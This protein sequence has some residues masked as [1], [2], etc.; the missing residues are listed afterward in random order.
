MEQMSLSLKNVTKTYPGV[1]ALNNISLDFYPGETHALVG[2]NGAGKST[3]IKIVSGAVAPDSGTITIFGNSFS[4]THPALSRQ[5]GVE[6]IYQEFNLVETLSAA[7]NI[8]LGCRDGAFVNYDKMNEA[9]KKLFREFD[10][11]IDPN[12]LVR[13]LSPAQQ[14][15]VEIVKAISKNARVLIMDEPTAPLTMKEVE[16]LFKTIEKIKKNGV[17]VLYVSHRL[18][19]IFEIAD[20]V[21]V[22]R[23]GCF[24]NTKKVSETNK[25]DLIQSMVGRELVE[26]YPPRTGDLGDVALE[27]KDVSGNGCSNISFCVRRGEILGFAGLVGAGRTELMRVLIGADRL[28]GGSVSVNGKPVH[29]KSPQ[30]AV[31][32]GIALIPEDRKNQGCFLNMDIEWNASIMNIKNLRGRFLLSRKLLEENAYKYIE[33]LKIKVPGLDSKVSNL[34]GGNQQKVALAKTLAANCKI[35]I[36]DEPTRGIDVGAKQEIYS[37]MR[38]LAEEG[39]AIIMISSEMEELLGMSDRVIVIRNGRNAGELIREEFSQVRVLE[40]ASGI[41]QQGGYNNAAKS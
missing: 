24:I 28:E 32:E 37:L 35:L 39:H 34:S 9:A 25:S 22:L 2:E 31:R 8:F 33:K 6:V 15:I 7:E 12:A 10:V 20:R 29:I 36:F 41:I 5:L 1:V 16:L 27:A 26:K 4:A 11:E 19:E 21:T 38:E 3:L 14:Q 40:Y 13:E 30:N 23:D 17:T 18:D